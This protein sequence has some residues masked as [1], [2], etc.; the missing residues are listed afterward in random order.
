MNFEQIANEISSRSNIKV[1]AKD[2]ERLLGALRKTKLPW[3]L[4]DFSDFPVP[5]V[6]ESM[7]VLEEKDVIS[8]SDSGFKLTAKGKEI[9]EDA[10]PVEDVSCS[11]CEGR[12]ITSERFSEI[13]KKFSE[14]SEEAS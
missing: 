11:N 2:V 10:H 6:F 13:G 3:E 5:A 7:K 12:G 9:T 8:M 14:N 1:S 4:V